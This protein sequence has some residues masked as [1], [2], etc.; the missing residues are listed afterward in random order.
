MFTPFSFKRMVLLSGRSARA[1]AALA[2]LTP[3]RADMMIALLHEES[4]QV[5]LAWKLGVCEEVVCR[6]VRALVELGLL[7][8]RTPPHDKRLRLVRLTEKGR[9]A[10]NILFDGWM[11][12]DGRETV[13][14]GSEGELLH[15]WGDELAKNG[16]EFVI[17]HNDAGPLLRHIRFTHVQQGD[18][19]TDTFGAEHAKTMRC[20]R[21][22]KKTR[23][24]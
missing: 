18:Y 19:W 2:D 11:P 7:E 12:D 20:H 8:K 17:G 1:F 24:A 3:A 4:S 21:N 16:F 6:M 14:A 22:F 15:E 9:K 10:L 13:Q 5:G 23:A